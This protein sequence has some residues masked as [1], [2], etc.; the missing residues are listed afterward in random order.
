MDSGAIIGVYMISAVQYS[1]QH[2][3]EPVEKAKNSL[4]GKVSID[5]HPFY[6]QFSR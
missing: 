1:F 2:M 4:K 3:S 6:I 5:P